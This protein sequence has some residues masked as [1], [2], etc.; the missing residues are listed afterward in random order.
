M[1]LVIADS[2]KSLW[3]VSL[4]TNH[5]ALGIVLESLDWNTVESR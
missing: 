1:H 4:Q 5:G 2:L 3:N